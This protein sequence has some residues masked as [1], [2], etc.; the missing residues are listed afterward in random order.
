MIDESG[1]YFVTQ[2]STDYLQQLIVFKRFVKEM[3]S[4]CRQRACF[5]LFR[6]TT[7][8]NHNRHVFELIHSVQ[9]IHDEKTI[10]R[11]TATVADIGR[12]ADVKQDEVR[13]FPTNRTDGACAI[14]CRQNSV[15]RCLQL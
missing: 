7:G 12:K 5:I 14:L 8:N 3:N 15:A 2:R 13:S 1:G 9:P 11:Y 10:P 6:F 4:A